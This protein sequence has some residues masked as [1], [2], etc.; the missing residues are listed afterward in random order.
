MQ[1]DSSIDSSLSALEE[2]SDSDWEQKRFEQK[3]LLL[4][5]LLQHSRAQKKRWRRRRRKCWWKVEVSEMSEK[6]FKQNFRYS[7]DCL[8]E[9]VEAVKPT[10]RYA[11]SMEGAAAIPSTVREPLL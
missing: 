10:C 2:E 5:A 1:S 3:I 8:D 9:L 7:R 4:A 6:E 11:G